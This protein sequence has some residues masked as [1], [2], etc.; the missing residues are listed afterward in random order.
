MSNSGLIRKYFSAYENKDRNAVESLSTDDFVLPV[1]TTIALTVKRIQTLLALY[2]GIPTN[3]IEKLFE[4]AT[5]PSSFTTAQ[6][7]MEADLGTWSCSL[8][9]IT[10]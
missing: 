1:H 7:I 4:E 3:D 10:G 2:R 9:T 8:S 6:S 5:K